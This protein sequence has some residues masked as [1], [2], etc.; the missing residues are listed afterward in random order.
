MSSRLGLIVLMLFC[1]GAGIHSWLRYKANY[2]PRIFSGLYLFSS[3]ELLLC[4][5]TFILFP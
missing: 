1:L 3:T 5:F 4:C 2:I